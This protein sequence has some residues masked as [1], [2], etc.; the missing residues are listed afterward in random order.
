M[1][2]AAKV[3][4]EAAA[5]QRRRDLHH[6]G[7][8]AEVGQEPGQGRAVDARAGDQNAEPAQG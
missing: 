6:R 8:R 5:P 4:G 3:D 1:C 7:L 2:R